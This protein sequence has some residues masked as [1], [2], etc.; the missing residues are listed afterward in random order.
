MTAALGTTVI[1]GGAGGMALATARIVGRSDAVVLTDVN[2]ARLH[3]A[4]DELERAD[5]LAY[6]YPCD[7]CDRGSVEKLV[8]RCSE[9]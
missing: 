3:A 1:T 8:R 2:E 6:G 9:I 7:V 5:I 4:V